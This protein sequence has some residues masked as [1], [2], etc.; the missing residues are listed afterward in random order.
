MSFM[1]LSAGPRPRDELRGDSDLLAAH[2]LQKIAGA[3]LS[4]GARA[5]NYSNIP[6]AVEF[7]R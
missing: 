1:L 7:R 5:G 2:G 4:G 3:V 6:H